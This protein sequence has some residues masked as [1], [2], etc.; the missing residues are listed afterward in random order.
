MARRRRRDEETLDVPN[1]TQ[2]REPCFKPDPW[3]QQENDRHDRFPPPPHKVGLVRAVRIACLGA[4]ALCVAQPPTALAA[5]HDVPLFMSAA[6]PVQQGFVRVINRSAQSGTVRIH[7]V[8]DAGTRVGPATLAIGA[9]ATAH[10]NSDDLEAGKPSKGL[11]GSIGS[12]QGDWRLELETDLDI[13]ALAYVRTKDGFLTSMHDLVPGERFDSGIL[14]LVPIF[15]PGGNRNQVSKLRLVNANDSAAEVTIV[16]VDDHGKTGEAAVHLTL[17]A[18]EARTLTAQ[19]LEAGDAGFSGR[20]GDGTGKWWLLVVT[21]EPVSVMSLLESPTG[22]L[23]NLSTYGAD[24]GIPL[25][26]AASNP[27]QQGFARITNY[28][29]ATGTVTIHAVDDSGRRRGP[30]SLAFGGFQTVH[31]NSDDLEN[32][33]PRKGLPSGLGS[34]QGDWRLELETDLDLVGAFAYIRTSDGFLTS[35]HDIAPSARNQHHVPIFNPGSNDNQRSSLR[36]VNLGEADADVAITGLDDRG[37]P[38]HSGE[39]RLTLPA[40]Q[41]RTITAQELEAGGAGFSGRFGDGGGKWQLS[42]SADQPVQVMSLLDSPTGNLTNLSSSVAGLPG[43]AAPIAEN[44]SLVS[45]LSNPILEVQLL[46]SD[47]DGDAIAY[48]LD[49]SPE[50]DGYYNAFVEPESGRLFAVLRDDGRDQ[51]AIAYRV[52]DGMRFSDKAH[53]RIT[54]TP[55]ASGGLG[56]DD[57]AP[58]TYGGFQIEFFDASSLPPSVDLSSHFPPAGNQGMQNSCVGWAV[59][60]ALKSF[61]ERLEER[62]EFAPATVFSPAWIYNQINRGADRG[63][64]IYEAL[65]LV[66]QRGAA[67]LRTMPYDP[68]D[69]RAR[70]TVSAS[71]EAA[72]YKGRSW[73]RLADTRQIKAALF[74]RLPV[75]IGMA[76][77]SSFNRLGGANS[78]YNTFVGSPLGG[79]AVTIVGYDDGR[80][81]GAF[82]VVNSYGASWGDRGYFWLPYRHLQRVVAEAYVLHD[83]TNDRE[84]PADAPR[85]PR[86]TVPYLPNLQVEGWSA[87]YNPQPGGDGRWQWTVVNTGT[88]TARLGADVNLILSSDRQLDSS[89]WWVQYEEI[90]FD[91]APGR[92]AVRDETNPR[93][94]T[95]PETLPAGTYYMAVW[96]DDLDE[97]R[98]S[99]ENDNVSPANRRVDI[100]APDLPDIAINH[101]WADWARNGHGVLEYEVANN[102]MARTTTTGWDINLIL[103]DYEDPNAGRHW[104]LFFEDA[105][106]ILYPGGV[107][108]RNANNQATFNLLYDQFGDAI[109]SGTY[110]I[111]LWV[112]DLDQERESN[113]V[114]NLSVGNRLVSFR[115]EGAAKA[116]AAE[117]GQSTSGGAVA[118]ADASAFNG[119]RLPAD[120]AEKAMR[121]VEI[122]DNPDGT[123]RLVFPG[124]N[125]ES[126][127]TPPQ[128]SIDEPLQHREAAIPPR[129]EK[130]IEAADQVV[131]PEGENRHM[132]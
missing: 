69:H 43:N 40:G 41:T 19:E 64:L 37:R 13:E 114:N 6:N 8:D 60:Y 57:A 38:P 10:F 121:R 72:Q 89:D 110:Y 32:G 17:A 96:V 55:L 85:R 100:M 24:Q 36:L 126:S 123:K 113:E 49:S 12:G 88:A 62:W 112:D 99:N 30:I 105:G 122:L 28:T 90:P 50:G 31:F 103:S 14:H 91:L 25:F 3:R 95:F 71:R 119:L 83:D 48:V 44:V 130:V 2:P 56:L 131:F 61:Q 80:F 51:V 22:N 34:G 93:A 5:R 4:V 47:A 109:P 15:N 59:G 97:V 65:D 87:E 102:G 79:H 29:E 67:T 66:V 82:K 94:F 27:T 81:G 33:N 26:I 127:A 115:W 21:A 76:T 111:S 42:V 125:A 52:T 68:L 11:S 9:E 129:F 104:F 78:V 16:G 118:A 120:L 101:W 128:P 92:R 124:D 20:L 63:S 35:V 7:A 1:A 107:L 45:D 108:Y 132:P 54:L 116:Q 46:G 98:E 18:G 117:A 106:R 75:V 73:W 84:Q 53:V 23:T 74:Q 77:Y 39:V 86:P 58:E 70:P